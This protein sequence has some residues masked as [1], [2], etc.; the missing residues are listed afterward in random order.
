MLNVLNS[1][2]VEL[3]IAYN[4]LVTVYKMVNKL[5]FY[6]LYRKINCSSDDHD[7]NIR[8]VSSLMIHICRSV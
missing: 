7:Y 1:M 2:D 3:G 5:M 8:S 6:Y 4:T